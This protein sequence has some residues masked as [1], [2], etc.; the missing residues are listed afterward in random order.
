MVKACWLRESMFGK[1]KLSI[2]YMNAVGKEKAPGS[3]VFGY[4]T[5]RKF[6]NILNTISY[7]YRT[8]FC[9]DTQSNVGKDTTEFI[10]LNKLS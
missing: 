4:M 10:L 7:A 6:F 1:H 2:L 9:A 3:S 8:A 5:S